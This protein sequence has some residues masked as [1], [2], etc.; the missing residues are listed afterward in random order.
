MDQKVNDLLSWLATNLWSWSKGL[1]CIA[2]ACFLPGSVPAGLIPEPTESLRFL[3]VDQLPE[4]KALPNPFRCRDGTFVSTIDQWHKQR[5]YLKDLVVHYMYGQM[6][7]S[8][9][10]VKVR[11]T[12]KETVFDGIAVEEHFTLTISR[13]GKSVQLG[14]ALFRPR[15]AKRPYPSIIKNCRVLFD[16]EASPE[17]FRRIVDYDLEAA[18]EAVQRGYLLCKFRREDLAPDHPDNRSQGVFPLYPNYDWGSIAVWA[19]GHQLVLDAL[20]QLDLADQ[21]QIVCTGHSRGGQTAVAAGIFDDRIDV[22]VPCTGGY[23]SCGT[24]RIRDPE[25][26]RGKLDYIEHLKKHAPHWFHSRY[27]R[28]AGQQNRLPFDAHTLVA[29][30]APRPFLNTNATGDEYNNTLSIEAGLRTG[31]IVYQWMQL[32][33]QCRL[34]WRPGRH[35]QNKVDWLALLDFADEILFGRKSSR[36]YNVWVYPEFEPFLPFGDRSESRP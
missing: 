34:H 26:V 1:S 31:K 6:P 15:S 23:G 2:L 10:D 29:L 14:I 12:W 18:R 33:N 13:I 21:D 8:P 16:A 3:P 32:G 19:W 28:F 24:L 9:D 20:I 5:E 25:G 22:V 7:P 36:E 30:I 35:A 4:Q 27:Y 11:Q 17:R